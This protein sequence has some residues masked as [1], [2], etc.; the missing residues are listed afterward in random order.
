MLYPHDGGENLRDATIEAA[1]GGFVQI[2]SYLLGVKWSS[3]EE[4]RECIRE[5]NMEA[6][7]Q[8]HTSVCQY[9]VDSFDFA[10]VSEA[11]TAACEGGHADTVQFLLSRGAS[12]S[13][14]KWPSDKSA[15]HCAVES[16]SWDL[17]VAV[18]GLESQQ[19]SAL[20]SLGRTPLI[21]AAKCGHVGLIDMLL[22]KGSETLYESME[23]PYF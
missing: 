8:G 1:K 13:S 4:R 3:E 11:M 20:D 9:L 7:G 5:A 15:L 18:L 17:V 16:G 14:V 19:V 2:V 23:F 22:N 10:D 12:L 6:A 21:I